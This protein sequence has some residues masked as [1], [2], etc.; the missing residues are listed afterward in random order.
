MQIDAYASQGSL[1][2]IR[3]VFQVKSWQSEKNF[4]KII[5][6]IEIYCILYIQEYI[7]L[8]IHIT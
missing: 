1:V 7:K 3:I 5:T 6:G 4:K 2:V 8:Q